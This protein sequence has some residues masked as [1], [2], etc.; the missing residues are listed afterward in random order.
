[1]DTRRSRIFVF[2]VL[3]SFFM[4]VTA[5]SQTLPH[6]FPPGV[7]QANKPSQQWAEYFRYLAAMQKAYETNSDDHARLIPVNAIKVNGVIDGQ[8]IVL[9]LDH[10]VRLPDGRIRFTNFLGQEIITP[11][12]LQ[13]VVDWTMRSLR[14]SVD[15]NFA[16]YGDLRKWAIEGLVESGIG[17]TAAELDKVLNKPAPEN[18][19]FTLSELYWLPKQMEKKDFIPREVHL[20]YGPAIPGAIGFTWLDTGVV[21]LTPI[22]QVAD[23]L[24]KAPMVTKHELIHSNKVLQSIPFSEGFDT[25]FFAS[26]PSM[27]S[28]DDHINLQFHSYVPDLRELAWVFFGYNYKRVRKEVIQFDAAGNLFID[29]KKFDHYAL[30]L[31]QIKAEYVKFFPKALGEFYGKIVLWS[32]MHHKLADNRAVLWIMMRKMYEP[33]ILGGRENTARW[34]KANEDNIRV[35]AEKAWE[36]S[37]TKMEEGK[38]GAM[39]QPMLRQLALLLGVNID[40][41]TEV[42]R[43]LKELKLKPEDVMKM[44]PEQ[45]KGLIWQVLESKMSG[46]GGR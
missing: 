37:G 45:V 16:F 46:K 4:T 21:Y 13:V 10:Y 42:S 29:E 11:A 1:M 17:L 35:D 43:F 9:V 39:A 40:N 19:R 23:Y 36:L 26:I 27:L 18:P 5:K 6:Y 8:K 33:T 22:G 38:E 44:S 30:M 15:A 20:G 31:N 14:E 2:S 7:I 3:F 25:E 28:S 32:A 34:L 41:E 12:E 24:L